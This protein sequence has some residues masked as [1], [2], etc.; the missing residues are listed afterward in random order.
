MMWT[1]KKTTESGEHFIVRKAKKSPFA[2]CTQLQCEF[3]SFSTVTTISTKT[4]R[5]AAAKKILLRQKSRIERM[6]W[7]AARKN[8]EVSDW[9]QYCF[10]DECRFKLR[11]DGR[12]WVWRTARK[13]HD[14]QFTR[15]LFNDRR[16]VH[17]WGAFSPNGTLPLI[18]AGDHCNA[19]DYVTILEQEGVHN[20]SSLALKFVDDNCPINRAKIVNQ[21]KRDNG[22]CRVPGPAH[23]PDLNP[24]EN[25]W[26]HVRRQLQSMTLAFES[27]EKTVNNVWNNIPIIFLQNLYQSMPSRGEHRLRNKRYATK[28]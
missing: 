4:I 22:V 16:S 20:L 3:N 18:K 15:S 25:V 23:S 13:R 26:A 19:R 10:S 12:I 9:K 6:K 7:C 5:R 21:W 28:Y 24:I 14:K 2:T 11:S 8:Q 1:F 17:F 27:L